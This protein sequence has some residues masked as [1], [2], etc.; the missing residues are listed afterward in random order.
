MKKNELI[1]AMSKEAG[2][3]KKDAAAA[4]DAFLKTLSD[5]L[6]RGNK[7]QLTGFG[8]FVTSV[9]KERQGKNPRTGQVTTIPSSKTVKFKAGK[10]LKEQVNN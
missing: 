9:R 1:D 5:D 2:L 10:Q 6:K 3:S 8:T 4:L 7:T